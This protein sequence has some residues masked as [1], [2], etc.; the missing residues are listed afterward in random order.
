MLRLCPSAAR[1]GNVPAATD[2]HRKREECRAYWNN[3][4]TLVQV[5]FSLEALRRGI[6]DD[7]G[8]WRILQEAF[9]HESPRRRLGCDGRF[10]VDLE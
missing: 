4:V 1:Y 6:N 10:D 8:R 2:V 3:S 9:S 7:G 5:F